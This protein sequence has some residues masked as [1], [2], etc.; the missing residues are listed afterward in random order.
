M[1]NHRRQCYGGFTHFVNGN[2]PRKRTRQSIVKDSAHA[3]DNHLPVHQGVYAERSPLLDL[4]YFDMATM[5]LLDMMHITSGVIHRHLMSCLTGDRLQDMTK[6]QVG[7]AA[8][9]KAKEAQ[10]LKKAE[11]KLQTLKDKQR[12]LAQERAQGRGAAQTAAY[13]AKTEEL[14]AKARKSIQNAVKALDKRK[15]DVSTHEIQY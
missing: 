5:T 15:E 10:E 3:R 4:S 6:K 12:K 14:I 7:E 8:K 2:R 9:K 13:I 1:E 11:D